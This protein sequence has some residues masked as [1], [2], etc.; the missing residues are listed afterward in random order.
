MNALKIHTKAY[1]EAF[2]RAKK[3]LKADVTQWVID[4][5]RQYTREVDA[6]IL[7]ILHKEFGF[8]KERLKKFYRRWV[9][10]H[11]E[12]QE[13]YQFSTPDEMEYLYTKLLEWEMGIRLSDWAEGRFDD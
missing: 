3:N 8:G 11:A 7:Y 1:D 5:D 6:S 4:C 2:E 10:A 12:L 13:K 9:D